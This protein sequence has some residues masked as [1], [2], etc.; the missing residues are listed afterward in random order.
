[1]EDSLSP[2]RFV[3]SIAGKKSSTETMQPDG[4]NLLINARA[5]PASYLALCLGWFLIAV[6]G[7]FLRRPGAGWEP[8][9]V[10]TGIA[11]GLA[12]WL[13][14]FRLTVIDD[15]LRYRTLLGRQKSVKLSDIEAAR[16]DVNFS[17]LVGAPERLVLEAKPEK[18]EINLKIFSRQHLRQ[19]SDWLG[20]K[21]K[22]GRKVGIVRREEL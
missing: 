18:L 6:L 2:A 22:G 12:I 21:L 17:R 16:I 11:I 14:A 1:M 19:V 3:A 7:F 20:P 10:P 9:Y 5:C 13:S 15:V 8:V 4:R